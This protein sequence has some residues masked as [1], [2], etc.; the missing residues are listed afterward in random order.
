[1]KKFIVAMFALVLTGCAAGTSGGNPSS[2]SD[3]ISIGS[4]QIGD[5]LALNEARRGFVSGMSDEGWV[6]G[7]NF[8]FSYF[9]AAGDIAA[10]NAMAQQIVDSGPDLI[11]G[12]ATS[13]S[14]A[15]A[16][17]TETIPI[18]ITAVTNPLSADLVD[19]FERP[20]RN[21]TG[22]SDLSPVSDQF[23]LM[24]RILPDI[25]TVGIIY[26][27]GEVNSRILADMARDRSRELGLSYATVTVASTADVAQATESIIGR[28]DVIYTPT[29]NTVASAIPVIVAIA[30]ENNVPII[31]GNEGHV[32]QGAMATLGVNYYRLGRQAAAM[33]GQI[34]R[35][36]AVPAEMPIQWQ[37][38]FNLVINMSAVERL[39]VTVPAD[40]L[41]EADNLFEE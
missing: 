32:F 36:E 20:G 14:Q 21:V 3:S 11:L 26:N 2:G 37:E 17:A 38:E 31:G 4:L 24:L 30:D 18:V 7:E 35:G 12:I 34:L 27:S 41:A 10:A 5:H 40:V 22:T 16:N 39:G 1:M 6:I 28:V 8:N 33:A 19:S 15:V 29:C 13:T 23:D 25:Q 9:S